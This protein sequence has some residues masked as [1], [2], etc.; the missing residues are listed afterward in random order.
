M[1]WRRHPRPHHLARRPLAHRDILPDPDPTDS[2]IAHPSTDAAT[3]QD[4][5]HSLLPSH[6]FGVQLR[7]PIQPSVTLQR[8]QPGPLCVVVG[9]QVVLPGTLGE[10]Q[11]WGDKTQHDR[12][13]KTHHH[14]DSR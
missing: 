14:S 3:V 9:Y 4:V 12:E 2:L 7:S 5:R 10:R 6:V 1:P 11:R 8:R 13:N